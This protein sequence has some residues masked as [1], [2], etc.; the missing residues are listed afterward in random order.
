MT[1]VNIG[2]KVEEIQLSLILP[3]L[4]TVAPNETVNNCPP[5]SRIFQGRQEILE[6]MHKFFSSNSGGQQIYV[7]HGLG[8]SGKTQIAFKF[9]KE[10]TVRFTNIIFVDASRLET[11]ERSLQNLAITKKNWGLS[12]GCRSLATIKAGR[13][14]LVL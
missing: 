13:M 5:P 2:S 6:N 9:I 11:I 7:L 3:N 12:T 8:G 10:S 14:A 4:A 1:R